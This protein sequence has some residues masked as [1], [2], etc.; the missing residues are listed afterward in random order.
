MI[1]KALIIFYLYNPKQVR[2][3]NGKSNSWNTLLKG[4][5]LLKWLV[6]PIE[7]VFRPL[8]NIRYILCNTVI[9]NFH[10]KY[11]GK[12]ISIIC[13]GI[14]KFDFLSLD[15]YEFVMIGDR[16]LHFEV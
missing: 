8:I 6:K 3:L 16:M 5:Y 9:T 15:H 11:E 12:S 1:R 10:Y 4:F 7:Y 13:S 2:V 14:K